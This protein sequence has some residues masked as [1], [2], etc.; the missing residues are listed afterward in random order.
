[1]DH[2][3]KQAQAHE[4]GLAALVFPK[5]VEEGVGTADSG[6]EEEVGFGAGHLGVEEGA[7][8]QGKGVP[9]DKG[10]KRTP[11][12]VLE[13]G[14]GIPEIGKGGAKE[15]VVRLVQGIVRHGNACPADR[16]AAT[17]KGVAAGLQVGRRI[18]PLREDRIAPFDS[19]R[20]KIKD[21]RRRIPSP[22]TS[23]LFFAAL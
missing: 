6:G 12:V 23:L 7:R 8:E 13:E 19:P 10:R 1:M 3:G 4:R 11:E 21:L 9:V 16:T 20:R 18:F 2:V 22:G 5:E 17:P 15:F 14:R